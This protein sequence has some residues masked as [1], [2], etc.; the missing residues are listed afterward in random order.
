MV[1]TYWWSYWEDYLDGIW[2]VAFQK[3]WHPIQ[4]R[5][6]FNIW[7]GTRSRRVQDQSQ[8]WS[9]ILL[10]LLTNLLE[11]FKS[12]S[13]TRKVGNQA[14]LVNRNA[15]FVQTDTVL[16]FVLFSSPK[17]WRR[18]NKLY[19][20]INFA[21]IGWEQ[22]TNRKNVQVPTVALETISSH[23]PAWRSSMQLT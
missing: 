12:S 21:L 23:S 20:S 15:F 19:R 4:P 18:R 13:T 3:S 14:I 5:W 16:L 6:R 17:P 9:L 22:T 10:L 8:I 2:K 11:Q 1:R 7:S